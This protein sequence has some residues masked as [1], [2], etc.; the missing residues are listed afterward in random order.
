MAIEIRITAET[1]EA[2]LSE[3]SKLVGA[4]TIIEWK[5]INEGATSQQAPQQPSESE[6]KGRRGRPRKSETIKPEESYVEPA[7][8]SSPSQSGQEPDT[9]ASADP[10]PVAEPVEDIKALQNKARLMSAEA[11]SKK[12]LDA[13]Q[14]TG[15]IRECGAE[16]IGE[17][18]AEGVKKLVFKLERELAK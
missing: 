13:G 4:N 8:A 14:I 9:T 18:D 12:V 2:A 10:E 16:K 5:E 3:M 15:L 17:L 1:A 11:L 7:E 6:P